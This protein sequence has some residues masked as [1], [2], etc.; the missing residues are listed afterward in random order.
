M[1]IVALVGTTILNTIQDNTTDS[2]IQQDKLQDGINALS[3]FDYGIVLFNGFFYLGAIVLAVKVR[4]SPVFAL[5]AILFL[6]VSVWLSS[7]IANIYNLFGQAG[8][9]SSAASSFTMVQTF[10]NNLPLITAG[11]GGLLLVILFT[12]VG[13]GRVTA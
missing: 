4:T 10:M 8:P 12:G 5:P 13:R 2:E 1:T 7:E 3:A 6:G 11:M 9:I